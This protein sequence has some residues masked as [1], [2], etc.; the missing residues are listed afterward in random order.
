MQVQLKGRPDRKFHL[1]PDIAELFLLWPGSPVEAVSEPVVPVAR[2]QWGV[3][4]TSNGEPLIS[5]RC[6]TCSL[7]AH[8]FEQWAS[9]MRVMVDLSKV[10]MIHCGVTEPP[11]QEI[12]ERFKQLV[13]DVTPKKRR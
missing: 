4:K 11:P 13:A 2:T 6:A 1:P 10:K 12:L 8:W 5:A 9:D 3:S 7:T